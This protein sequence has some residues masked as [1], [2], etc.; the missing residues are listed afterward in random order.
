[1]DNITL[2]RTGNRPVT[3]PGEELAAAHSGDHDA[4]R[5][6]ELTLY[7]HADGRYILAVAYHTQWQGEHDHAAVYVA[8]DAD[9]LAAQTQHIDPMEHVMGFPPGKQFDERR[10]RLEK[11]LRTRFAVAL[12]EILAEIGPEVI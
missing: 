1:M 10:E 3:F 8:G 4:N 7:R 2:P 6:H 11:D 5:W 12:G 9:D